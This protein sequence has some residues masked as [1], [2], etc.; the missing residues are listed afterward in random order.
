MRNHFFFQG[1][2]LVG[3]SLS[4]ADAVVFPSMVFYMSTLAKFGRE[5]TEYMGDRMERWWVAGLVWI[6]REKMI[7]L[8]AELTTDLK[9]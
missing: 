4:I 7:H 9:V 1:P 3:P 2:Y 5:R 8:R 6:H